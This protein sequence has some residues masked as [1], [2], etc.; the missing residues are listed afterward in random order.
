MT[1]IARVGFGAGLRD[2]HATGVCSA[3]CT[4]G[5]RPTAVQA[6]VKVEDMLAPLPLQFATEQE[7]CAHA[8]RVRC[9]EIWWYFNGLARYRGFSKPFADRDGRWW[10]T[11][12]PGFA[13]PVDFFSSPGDGRGLSLRPLLGWQYPV[14]ADRSNSKVWMNV[15]HDLSG[16]DISRVDSDK[17]R[18]VRKGLKGLELT[19]LDAANSEVAREACEVWNSHVARTGWNTPMTPENFARTWR[20]LPDW[21]GT[22]VIGARDRESGAL[23]SWVIARVING[24]VYVDTLASHTERLDNRPND[25]IV[26]ST[27]ASAAAGGAS[28]AH[29]SL[30][31]GNESLERF[32]ASMGF[33]SYAFPARLVLRWPVGMLLRSFKP[34]VYQRLQGNLQWARTTPAPAVLPAN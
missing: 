28:R 22:T 19:T 20:E 4:S 34:R 13:W 21:P 5:G 2:A 12:K 30:R 29:Y 15:I 24:V 31:S 14:D 3:G 11:V 25:T 10:Y 1:S 7:Y 32:K 16:F 33:E 8:R 27:L 23:C 26:Y 18:A 17:R 9:N 6:A